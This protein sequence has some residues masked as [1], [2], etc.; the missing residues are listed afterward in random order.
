MMTHKPWLGKSV[1]IAD[2][3]PLMAKCLEKMFTNLGLKVVG[4]A[5]NGLETIKLIEEYQPDLVSLDIVMPE[6]NGIEVYKRIKAAKIDIKCIIISCLTKE[7]AIFDDLKNIVPKYILQNKPINA[8]ELEG[9]L[10]AV[11]SDGKID[12][13]IP[14]AMKS[15]QVTEPEDDQAGSDTSCDDKPGD[16]E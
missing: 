2:D 11:F 14:T 4:I 5:S 16:G 12:P 8:T 15:E 13:N 1:I 9:R 7:A 10:T 3:S 6:M